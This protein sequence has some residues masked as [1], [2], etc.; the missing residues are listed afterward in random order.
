MFEVVIGSGVIVSSAAPAPDPLEYTIDAQGVT[1]VTPVVTAAA[2]ADGDV[3]WTKPDGTTT[4]TGKSPASGNFNQIGTYKITFADFSAVTEFNSVGDPG[5]I[6]VDNFKNCEN[7]SIL[8]LAG[9]HLGSLDLDGF[10]SL[11]NL[12]V[13]ASFIAA[14]DLSPVVE[15]LTTFRANTT[16][17]TSLD[18]SA[19][20][21][22]VYCDVSGCAFDTTAIDDVLVALDANGETDG[23]CDVSSN[24]ELASAT[25]DAAA[26][27]LAGKGW[28]VLYDFEG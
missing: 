15:T 23:Y 27:S 28:T 22:L 2:L 11:T 4:F 25:G 13:S 8:N 7:L 9:T 17:L 14:L 5:V 20:T 12:D 6:G 26:T 19:T 18:V 3:T 21:L 10:A 24:S 1:V 16:S